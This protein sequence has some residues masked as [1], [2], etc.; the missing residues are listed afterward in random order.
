MDMTDSL[1]GA[2]VFFLGTLAFSCSPQSKWDA[3]DETCSPSLPETVAFETLFAQYEGET[4]LLKEDAYITG[5]V[6]ANDVAG[7][8]FGELYIQEGQ[9]AT[10][11]GLRLELDGRDHHLFHPIGQKV[12]VQTKGL[13]LGHSGNGYVLGGPFLAFGNLGVGL[14]GKLGTGAHCC[15]L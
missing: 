5:Y 4:V 3:P 9:Q 1:K 10:G 14:T 7:N 11:S 8:L 13:Y 2:V 15:S 12:L 6:S